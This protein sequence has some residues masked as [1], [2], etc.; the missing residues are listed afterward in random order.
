LELSINI[1]HRYIGASVKLVGWSIV[2][3]GMYLTAACSVT[4]R[5]VITALAIKLRFRDVY[6]TISRGRS[7]A[8]GDRRSV[9]LEDLPTSQSDFGKV[10]DV[11]QDYSSTDG[12][13]ATDSFPTLNSS[14]LVPSV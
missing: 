11:Q 7:Y 10:Q 1:H 2:E 9:R 13:I 3:P 8:A 6:G 14:T 5:P 4:L 12:I